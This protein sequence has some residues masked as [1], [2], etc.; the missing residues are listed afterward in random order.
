MRF[1]ICNPARISVLPRRDSHYLLEN[2]LQMKGTDP[3]VPSKVREGYRSFILSF[4][5]PTSTLNHFN[6]GID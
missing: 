5:V 2:S 1:E 3:E 4:D 6:L